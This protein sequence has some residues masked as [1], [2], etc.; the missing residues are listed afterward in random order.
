MRERELP[1][2]KEIQDLIK[3]VLDL[4]EML[5]NDVVAA[6]KREYTP[7]EIQ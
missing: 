2:T 5:H 6:L 1:V 4:T 7:D 3:R